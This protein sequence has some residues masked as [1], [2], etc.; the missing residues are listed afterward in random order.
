M[1]SPTVN[2]SLTF[3]L[4]TPWARQKIEDWYVWEMR[5]GHQ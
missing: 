4:K 5:D 2:F 1:F 3:L